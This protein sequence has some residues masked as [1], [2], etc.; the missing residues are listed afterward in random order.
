MSLFKIAWR[1][2]QQRALS[3]WLTGLSMALG[4][5]LVVAV[6]V[7]YQVV[8]N[9]Y[10][11]NTALGYNF[12]VGGKN[13]SKT[14]LIRSIVFHVGMPDEPLPW[15]YYLQFVERDGKF[16][17][18]VARAV[19]I[20]MGDTYDDFRVIGTTPE[21]FEFELARGRKYEFEQ[22]TVFEEEEFFDA[23]IGFQVAQ[24][25]GLGLDDTFQ[26]THG[27]AEEGADA[28]I[29]EDEFKVVGILA[30]TGTS[31]DRGMFV[32]IEGFYLLEGHA[33]EGQEGAAEHGQGAEA[34]DH[35]HDHAHGHQPLPPEQREVTALLV[36]AA[37]EFSDVTAMVLSRQINE[38][39][40]AQAASPVI[41]VAWILQTY[42]DPLLTIFFILTVLI[43]L[44]A[45]VGVMVSIY[46]SMAARG[47]EI[48]VMR[49]LGASRGTVMAIVLVES[50]ILSLAGG[51]A[52]VLLGHALVAASSQFLVYST[53]VTAGFF[54]YNLVEL[55]LIPGLILLASVVGY[56][57]AMTAYRTDVS[58]TLAA[59]P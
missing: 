16:T 40:D 32:N 15:N 45:A 55:V 57:P 27:V 13:G 56:L 53:G 1:S 24:Q 46:N 7:I 8:S 34:H 5:G 42:V 2:L 17:S 51:A 44:V 23:V 26:T 36:L 28:H 43:V 12:I 39:Q 10:D 59:T 35:A 9:T 14:D 18:K 20:C 6:L 11:S 52:G 38:G 30:P 49:A 37:G 22:G 50:I 29:H 47:H 58:R 41:E 33:K 54:D 21:I 31:M 25:T 48:A 19:P 3:S 4:V